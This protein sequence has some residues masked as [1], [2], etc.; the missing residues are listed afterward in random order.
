M[1]V[2]MMMA[3]APMSSSTNASDRKQL[4]LAHGACAGDRAR[5]DGEILVEVGERAAR[6]V[7]NCDG[8]VGINFA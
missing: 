5:G 7:A 1:A 4:T 6:E 3:S 8:C 2:A